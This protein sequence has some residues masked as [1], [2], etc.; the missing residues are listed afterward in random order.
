MYSTVII[1]FQ[2][3]LL[4]VLIQAIHPFVLV[5]SFQRSYRRVLK[6]NDG[7]N[8][9]GPMEYSD[10]DFVPGDKGDSEWSVGS[11]E[12]R[13]QEV[14]EQ[15]RQSNALVTENW[16][17]GNWRVRGFSLDQFSAVDYASD[18]ENDDSLVIS[19][20]QLS[21]VKTSD[22]DNDN[23]NDGQLIVVGRTDGSVCVV[24]VGT[25]YF[26]RFDAKLQAT[27]GTSPDTVR[28]ESQLVRDAS[29]D[30]GE[31]NDIP[32]ELMHQFMAH[33]G[34]EI[35]ALF[36]M[37][38][39]DDDTIRV[40][41]GDMNG[42][43]AIWD[44]GEKGKVC[45]HMNLDDGAHADR[46]VALRT[47][48]WNSSH[49]DAS[50]SKKLLVSVSRE[51]SL[52]LWDPLT[53]DA[54]YKCQISTSIVENNS[55][56]ENSSSVTIYCADVWDGYL[57]LGLSTGH[58]VTYKV[59]EL[60]ETASTMGDLCTL[61]NGCFLAHS[62]GVT[63]ISSGGKGRLDSSSVILVTGGG[64]DGSVKQWELLPRRQ[65]N[66][67]TMKLEHWPRL[68]NQRMAKRAHTFAGHSDDSSVTAL[69][70]TDATHF[71]SA[72]TDGTI[73][74]WN[75]QTG[76]ELFVLD[77]F[78]T[79]IQS[80]CLTS[81]ALISNGMKQFVCLHDFDVALDEFEQG[82]QFEW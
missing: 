21:L 53:G 27:E 67:D 2:C 65:A 70:Y 68:A 23:N 20:S 34:Q 37:R 32:F 82:S 4:F 77:G 52:A 58:V 42:D 63:A 66:V 81:D 3:A 39:D 8:D 48:T 69:A 55:S 79:S 25:Q 56:E 61:P 73:R 64:E 62:D 60:L 10:F 11:L 75:P 44:L 7:G 38:D 5:P 33:E 26:T 54:I 9:D 51:G 18:D 24:E 15:E 57:F 28:I 16:R 46:I 17:K 22:D 31:E 59:D 78:S 12:T 43:I 50:E 13:L 1:S 41:T 47:L 72:G 80:L 74:A 40:V 76:E 6:N 19:I 30:G 49:D 35:T 71:V 36:A 45:P 14:R 29:Q